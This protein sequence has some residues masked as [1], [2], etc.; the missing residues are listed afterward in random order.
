MKNITEMNFMYIT[1]LLLFGFLYT[2][3]QKE[4]LYIKWKDKEKG[5]IVENDSMQ[6]KV[7][8]Y[9]EMP[10]CRIV[11]EDVK[12]IFRYVIFFYKKKIKEKLIDTTKLIVID[13]KME[14]RNLLNIRVYGVYD[15]FVLFTFKGVKVGLVILDGAII[16]IHGFRRLPKI[17]E[18]TNMVV[19]VPIVKDIPH[20]SPRLDV[21]YVHS[22]IDI[23]LRIFWGKKKSIERI[24][25]EVSV[26]LWGRY[27]GS[28]KDK[29]GIH[30]LET[31]LEE[32]TLEFIK[33]FLEWTDNKWKVI[34]EKKGVLMY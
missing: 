23:F 18:E 3:G 19:F 2:K 21:P 7:I 26:S 1:L 17:F 5:L 14:N 20:K 27:S 11:N 29:E 24:R 22:D 6:L 13:A 31:F 32:S 34:D 12:N 25:A 4:G 16:K 9:E 10:I 8:G 30:N 33:G 28:V 15:S